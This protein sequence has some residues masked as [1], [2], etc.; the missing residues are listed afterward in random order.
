MFRALG[1]LDRC[2][3]SGCAPR[4]PAT[5]P[6]HIDDAPG[7]RSAHRLQVA[8]DYLAKRRAHSDGVL[9]VLSAARGKCAS[10]RA[11]PVSRA[12]RELAVGSGDPWHCFGVECIDGRAHVGALSIRDIPRRPGAARVTVSP[13]LAARAPSH[14]FDNPSYRRR[15]SSCP[16]ARHSLPHRRACTPRRMRLRART[17]PSHHPRRVAPGSFPRNA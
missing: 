8:T 16:R 2:R 12:R 5:L 1:R 6:C 7:D 17:R 9:P 10:M 3:H 11:R 14:A 15:A 13:G 4:P